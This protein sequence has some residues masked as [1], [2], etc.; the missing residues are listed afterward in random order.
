MET[1]NDCL[2][3]FLRQALAMLRG[4]TDD[5]Q[6]SWQMT[7]TVGGLPTGFNRPPRLKTQSIS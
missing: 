5:P 6:Q 4:S 3:C 1:G 7:G 2:V